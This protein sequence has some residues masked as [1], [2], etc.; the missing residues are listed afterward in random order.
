MI[1]GTCDPERLSG[2][3]RGGVSERMMVRVRRNETYNAFWEDD[4][5][6]GRD[7]TGLRMRET[8]TLRKTPVGVY[9]LLFLIYFSYK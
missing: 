9:L 1:G 8:G 5:G 7:E 3:S 2:E 6:R 4:I